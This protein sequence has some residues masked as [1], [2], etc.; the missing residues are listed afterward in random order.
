MLLEALA[1]LYIQALANSCLLNILVPKAHQIPEKDHKGQGE[2]MINES[3]SRPAQ[4]TA[5]DSMA[6]TGCVTSIKNSGKAI[7]MSHTSAIQSTKR[8]S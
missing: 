2:Q 6:E 3:S 4:P 7:A 1:A 8:M 5:H